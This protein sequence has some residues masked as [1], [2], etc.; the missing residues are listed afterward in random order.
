MSLKIKQISY[1]LGPVA[2]LVMLFF[3]CATIH[4]EIGLSTKDVSALT[5]GE[6]NEMAVVQILLVK[7]GDLVTGGSGCFVNAQGALLTDWHII[8]PAL[9]DTS[10]D[11]LVNYETLLYRARIIDADPI[12]DLALLAVPASNQVACVRFADKAAVPSGNPVTFLAVPPE[13]GLFKGSR[14]QADVKHLSI[15]NHRPIDVAKPE[16]LLVDSDTA[17]FFRGIDLVQF[18]SSPGAVES[19]SDPAL[20]IS[21]AFPAESLSI[22]SFFFGGRQTRIF[23]ADPDRRMLSGYSGGV[24]FDEDG[25]CLGIFQEIL[26]LFKP[27]PASR[28]IHPD[29]P[30][31]DNMVLPIMDRMI[32]AGQS[33]H[34]IMAFLDARNVAYARGD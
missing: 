2:L 13:L 22:F 19:L 17:D 26:V 31:E 33:S 1:S 21:F 14:Y 9:S 16:D 30:P 11:V 29:R 24:W 18:L 8:E 15:R 3:S 32:C 23:Y 27:N 7:D 34:A 10:I 6:R 5:A 20:P 25:F 28:Y 4:T 12:A